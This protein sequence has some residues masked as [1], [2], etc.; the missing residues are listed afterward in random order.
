MAVNKK[1]F[2]NSEAKIEYTETG[3]GRPVLFLHGGG[4]RAK[5]YNKFL[6]LLSQKYQVIAPDL[7]CFGGSS[8]PTR[9]WS[10][11][12]YAFFFD[13]FIKHLK[14]RQ[15]IKRIAVVGHSWGGG[16]ALNL[17]VVNPNI[18]SLIVVNAAGV[19]PDYCRF[20]FFYYIG[21]KRT[22]ITFFKYRALF[23]TLRIIKDFFINIFK[24]IFK[25]RLIYKIINSC[26]Y[27]DYEGF[28]QISANTLIL[29]GEKDELFFKE[30]ART[31]GRQI[32]DSQLVFLEGNHDWCLK[33]YNMF[34]KQID[35]FIG[36]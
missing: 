13:D 9:I 32:P 26:I 20:K 11:K 35:N 12:D 10:L 18:T 16:V 34:L 1:Y 8:V 23:L 3:S 17:A 29:W 36:P 30:S 19:K 24:R 14:E 4:I 27:H 15:D 22:F 33:H 7:P 28:D 21:F 31:L 5:T 2:R 25:L 6:G